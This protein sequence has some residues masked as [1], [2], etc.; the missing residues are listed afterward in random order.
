[1][2]YNDNYSIRTIVHQ[3]PQWLNHFCS[4]FE[5][6]VRLPVTRFWNF[7]RFFHHYNLIKEISLWNF[8]TNRK[9]HQLLNCAISLVEHLRT[10]YACSSSVHNFNQLLKQIQHVVMHWNHSNICVLNHRY[11]QNASCLQFEL[12]K[13]GM[14]KTQTCPIGNKDVNP[15]KAS[16]T[17]GRFKNDNKTEPNYRRKSFRKTIKFYLVLNCWKSSFFS[18]IL[19][20]W[21]IPIILRSSQAPSYYCWQRWNDS[22][23][24]FCI[25]G[26]WLVHC[27]KHKNVIF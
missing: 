25:F 7:N 6:C 24:L 8:C 22:M 19:F 14:K 9:I 21:N 11:L 10:A 26:L 17:K 5:V 16:R 1:M 20:C 23:I 3:Q 12:N 13:I 27:S 15:C 18:F 4:S 2:T